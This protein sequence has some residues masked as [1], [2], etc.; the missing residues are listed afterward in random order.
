MLGYRSIIFVLVA[1]IGSVLS[2]AVPD[3]TFAVLRPVAVSR[4]VA[5]ITIRV[6]TSG[7]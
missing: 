4:P 6:R 3:P 7:K 2:A 1:F 5:R